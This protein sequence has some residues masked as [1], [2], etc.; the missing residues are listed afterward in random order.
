MPLMFVTGI[1][2]AG[3]STVREELTRR[4]FLAY[5]TDEHEI[6][7]W[8]NKVTGKVT[9]L[10]DST[11]RTPEFIAQNDWIADPQRVRQLAAEGEEHTVFLCGSVG[12]DGEVMQF[13]DQV[14]LLTIDEITMRRRLLARTAHDFGTKTHELNLLLAWLETIDEQY[15][16]YGAIVIDA[17]K[18]PP[19]VV[20]EI[21]RLG[22]IKA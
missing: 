19:V 9:R 13:F 6:A 1:S 18:P 21:L 22:A 10:V 3:K 15:L 14:F 12:N 4:G 16:R 5:D 17:T 20:D 7:Q 11:D 8:T 2:G